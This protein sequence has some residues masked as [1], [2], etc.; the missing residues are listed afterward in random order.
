[1][2]S[3]NTTPL[4][5]NLVRTIDPICDAFEAAWK[6]GQ[7]P[8]IEEHLG[9]VAEAVR[10]L[11]LEELICTELEWRYLL[12]EQ[13]AA[14]EYNTRFPVFADSFADWLA[15]A[16]VSAERLRASG[17]IEGELPSLSSTG[18]S[19]TGTF[20]PSGSPVGEEI[21]PK[22]L[23][24]YELLEPLGAG[25]MGK[26]YKARHRKLGKLVAMKLLRGHEHPA[27]EALARFLREMRAAGGLD[28]P[29]VME[30]HD[31]GEQAG[32]AYLVMKLVEG[33]DLAR[34]VRER[35]PLPVAEACELA[36]QAALGLQHLH[37]RGLVHRDIK[38]SNLMRTPD[39]VVKI[40]DLGLARWREEVT[41]GDDL[42]G[43]GRFMGTPNYLAPEQARNA[44]EADVR[45]DLYGLGG[46]LFYL[47]TGRSPFAHHEDGVG[48]V[49]AHQAEA[50]PDVRSLR[51]EIPA[52]LAE[53]VG[54]LL[55]KRPEDRPQTPREVAVSLAEWAEGH[56]PDDLALLAL[57]IPQPYG[58]TPRPPWLALGVFGLM[59]LLGLGVLL[60]GRGRPGHGSPS[61]DQGSVNPA[62]AKVQVLSLEVN[63]FANMNGQFDQ[64]RGVL[65]MGRC[66]AARCDDSVTVDARLSQPAYAYLISF[67]P[68]GIE[69]VCFPEGEDEPP[70]LTDRPRYPSVSR[71]VNYGLNEGE[72]L[73]VFALVVS[74][75]PLPAYK[76][77][78]ARRGPSPWK[79]VEAAR[80]VLGASTVGLLGSPPE[81]GPLL[82]ID[83][84]FP[85]RLLQA[86]PG[87]VWRD[88]GTEVDALTVEDPTGQR[89]KG[90]EVRGKTTVVELTEWL[91]QAPE[92]EAVAAVGFA[93]LPKDRP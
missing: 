78:R 69:E 63:H 12:G 10:P 20:D 80:L 11:L 68:D 64:P 52:G 9:Q 56:R 91:R 83:G 81:Q 55:S 14:E 40:L 32:V 13:P 59:V 29:N 58:G 21:V 41:S 51:P 66:F 38:P 2:P 5:P 44:A 71:G 86:P 79:K 36:R 61:G 48:K 50:P 27:P 93:V 18:L 24:E 57:R 77:W 46:T 92:V 3:P 22:V 35:G 67:R 26:V 90:K 19:S 60:V 28:H 16:R 17:P 4:P 75:G 30:A 1:M 70:T 7:R 65:G 54:R 43:E 8:M 47:L 53:L 88:D 85:G 25:G 76:G 62:P 73:Q 45:A 23:G 37:E 15:Q 6:Q 87:V 72:G 31:A 49:E 33:T 82:A 74:S 89:A 84:L 42:T 39:G 34:L